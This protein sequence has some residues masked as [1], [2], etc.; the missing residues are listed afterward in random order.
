M[1]AQSLTTIYLWVRTTST[2]ADY[3]ALAT[4][5]DWNSGQ[6]QDYTARHNYGFSRT[7]GLERGW[8]LTLQPNG[9][10]AWNL[11]DGERRL[12]YQPTADRQRIN[13]GQWHHLAFSIDRARQEAR[14]YFDGLQVAL[15]SLAELATCHNGALAPVDFPGQ[16]EQCTILER[17]LEAGELARLYQSRSARPPAAYPTHPPQTPLRVMAWN[18]WNGGREDGVDTGVQRVVE[19]IRGSGADLVAM[20][21]TYGSGPR[22]AD[23]L[24][25]HL[26]LRSSNLSV[27]SRYPASAGH[28]HFRPFNLGGVTLNPAPGRGLKLFTLWIDYLPDFC[29]DVRQKDITSERL[30]AAEAQTRG[31][32]IRAILNELAIHIADKTPL[33]VA[34]DFNSPSHL[35]WI[36]PA[37]PM[38]CDL[39]VEWP[40]SKDMAAAGFV[41]AYRHVHPDPI[42]QPGH[43]WTPRNP[44]SWQ[45]RIDYVYY[46]G[47]NLR[48]L[49]AKVLDQ[50]PVRWPSD[51]AAVLATFE[52]G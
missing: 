48:C 23:M 39:V 33:I 17:R 10:W 36:Q 49:E 11:G 31:A 41:D 16:V 28:D 20:Q 4:D 12:D 45:D 40:V 25:Y 46:R 6:I 30:I 14:L 19:C 7:S 37:S 5:K 34:G 13:D 1:T 42:A 35:D 51:H 44:H 29:N 21:E 43:T 2:A 22:I 52:L 18:I 27:I 47:A 32:E 3:P 9:A 8:A 38:H 15:Y 24:G 26:Y 50:H